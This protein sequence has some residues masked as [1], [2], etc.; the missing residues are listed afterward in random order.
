VGIDRAGAYKAV[1]E[2]ELAH[3]DIVYDKFHLIANYNAVIDKIRRG[4]WR[5]AGEQ[6][7]TFIKGQ[8]YNL[9]RNPENLYPVEYSLLPTLLCR[10][11]T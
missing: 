2:E 10:A 1:I 3:A 9:F 6:D 11:T 8:R 5:A 7:K 4:E